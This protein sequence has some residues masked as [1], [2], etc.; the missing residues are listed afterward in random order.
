MTG[1]DLKAKFDTEWGSFRKYIAAHPLT[2][3]WSGVIGGVLGG[4][5]LRGLL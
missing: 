5:L 4:A 2:G 3:F 1:A